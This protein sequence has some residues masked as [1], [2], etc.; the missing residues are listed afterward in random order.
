VAMTMAFAT[1]SLSRLVHGI[2]CRM[3]DP[4]TFKTLFMNPFTYM[5]LIL[6]IVLLGSV[7]LLKPLQGIF[8]ISP[9]TTPQ[10]TS[11]GILSLVP[12]VVVQLG[13]HVQK[14]LRHK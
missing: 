11:I 8:E 4:L 5:A 12:L 2:N 3:D 13:K 14:G 7:L 6:G 9:L 1:L 10:L